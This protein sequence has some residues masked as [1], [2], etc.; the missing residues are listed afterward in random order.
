MGYFDWNDKYLTG[1]GLFDDQHQQLFA[2][3]NA[4]HQAMKEGKA[5]KQVEQ[6]LGELV[7][8]A[9]TH[10]THEEQQM[11]R[12]HYPEYDKHKLE[13][14]RFKSTAL[15]LQSDYLQGST[16]VTTVDIM[17]LVTKWLV[18]H[19]QATDQKYGPFLRDKGVR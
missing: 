13:H 4:F 1:I 9:A 7:Q 2:L 8:Y 19:I 3:V 10:F 14:E 12:Y 16:Q 11:L 18:E 17:S 6:M 15:K 5:R